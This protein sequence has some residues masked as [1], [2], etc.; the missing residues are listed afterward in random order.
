MTPS[1][2]AL[3]IKAAT[4]EFFFTRWAG[5]LADSR[6]SIPSNTP[7]CVST[8]WGTRQ[9]RD[10]IETPVFQVQGEVYRGARWAPE[11]FNQV[12]SC[13]EQARCSLCLGL[14]T[15]TSIMGTQSTLNGVLSGAILNLY[16]HARALYYAKAIVPPLPPTKLQ[17]Q[18]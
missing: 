17:T 5:G 15:L 6:I 8:R 12:T 14:T 18:F 7:R 11:M 4:S 3:E 2:K 9:S 10:P 16:C 1:G 13:A